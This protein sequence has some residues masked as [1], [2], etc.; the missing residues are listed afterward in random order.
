MNRIYPMG[1]LDAL[2]LR[3]LLH[4]G[5]AFNINYQHIM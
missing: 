3:H 4:S 2:S 1:Q 5:S